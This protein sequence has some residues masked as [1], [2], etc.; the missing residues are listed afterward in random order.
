MFA[1]LLSSTFLQ[2]VYLWHRIRK[3]FARERVMQPCGEERGG[4][5]EERREEAQG[6]KQEVRRDF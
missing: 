3:T 5:R 1:R 4:E 6:K 2:S